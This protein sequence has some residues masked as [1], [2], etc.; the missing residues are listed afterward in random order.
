MMKI[1]FCTFCT[2]LLGSSIA[3]G[4][5]DCEGAFDDKPPP[6]ANKLDL[7][8]LGEAID[9]IKPEALDGIR[10]EPW[11]TKPYTRIT[12]PGPHVT[13]GYPTQPLAWFGFGSRPVPDGAGGVHVPVPILLAGP[14]GGCINTPNTPPNSAKMKVEPDLGGEGAEPPKKAMLG[15][16]KPPDNSIILV[17]RP[18]DIPS[19]VSHGF[20]VAALCDAYDTDCARA[21][22]ERHR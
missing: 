5:G 11:R 16:A 19:I 6:N 17:D 8:G 18:Q 7:C 3:V 12:A 22:G 1:M 21:L 10:P 2:L 13:D 14:S 4:A 20:L 15:C 9:D